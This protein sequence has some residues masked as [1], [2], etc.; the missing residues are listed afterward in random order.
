MKNIG[1]VNTS[2]INNS[3]Y[4]FDISIVN[5]AKDKEMRLPIPKGAIEY[6]EIEDNLA[7]FGL[8]G[9]C[10]IVNFYGILQQLNILDSTEVQHM[11]IDIVN[12][13]FKNSEADDNP[14]VRLTLFATLQQG[15][16]ASQNVISKSVNYKFEEYFVAQMRKQ[17]IIPFL[18]NSEISTKN[19]PGNLIYNIL[20]ALN[21][22]STSGLSKQANFNNEFMLDDELPYEIALSELYTGNKVASVFD[23]VSDLYNF[24]TFRS[25]D[26]ANIGGGPAII[27]SIN[28]LVD[29][30]VKRFFTLQPLSHFTTG[31]Y[32]KLQQKAEDLSDYVMEEFIVGDAPVSNTLNT[33]FIDNYALLTTNYD[34]V[35]ANK[36]IDYTLSEIKTYDPTVVRIEDITYESLRAD[37]SKEMLNGVKPN[38][39]DRSSEDQI[40]TV[41]IKK[42]VADDDLSKLYTQNAVKKSFVFDNIALTF[43]VPGNTYRKT[44]KFIR[45]KSPTTLK[46][47]NGDIESKSIDGYWL[48]ILLKHVFDGDYYTNEF[49]CVRLHAG[50]PTYQTSLT[51]TFNAIR[52]DGSNSPLLNNFKATPDP[53]PITQIIDQERLNNAVSTTA[54][55][56][57]NGIIR[58]PLDTPKPNV[59]SNRTV[60]PVTEKVDPTSVLDYINKK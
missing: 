59:N 60:L 14:D 10:R 30:V 36:W 35:M 43:T 1:T 23:V 32:D 45:I 11:F 26:I 25:N 47:K 41:Q 53:E 40:M 7:N 18:K 37:F 19:T 24:V 5:T 52:D 9:K 29:G 28:K 2:N 46:S 42:K 33:N 21:K 44:G 34:D 3:L 6:M 27:S 39:P 58:P 22:E 8:V 4:Q 57:N 51:D 55:P 50:D 48:V 20:T 12:T 56:D 31:L 13:D 15:V 49:T 17:T 54:A 16:E 38:L